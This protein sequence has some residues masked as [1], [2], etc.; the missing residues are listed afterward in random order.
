MMLKK[1]DKF[2]LPI[3]VI[4]FVYL[5]IAL[6]AFSGYYLRYC[7]VLKSKWGWDESTLNSCF[8]LISKSGVT[9]SYNFLFSLSLFL[10]IVIIVLAYRVMVLSKAE[11]QEE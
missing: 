2:I 9:D 6:P 5:L 1:F 4:W 7:S 10:S 8:E 11:G 3:S